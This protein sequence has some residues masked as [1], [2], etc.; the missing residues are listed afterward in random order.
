MKWFYKR[1]FHSKVVSNVSIRRFSWRE[2]N[3]VCQGWLEHLPPHQHFQLQIHLHQKHCRSNVQLLSNVTN[4]SNVAFNK[5]FV[6]H[7]FWQW[8]QMH[9]GSLYL[10][11]GQYKLYNSC[12]HILSFTGLNCWGTRLLACT[13]RLW[14]MFKATPPP[15]ANQSSTAA[16]LTKNKQ[17]IK[18]IHYFFWWCHYLHVPPPPYVTFCY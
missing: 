16:I 3:M 15:N 9:S 13:R 6:V 8:A 18:L 17:K 1:P 14:L 4:V 10:L 5:D 2:L 11:D 7:T 12:S